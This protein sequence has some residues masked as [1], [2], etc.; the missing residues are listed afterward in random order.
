MSSVPCR[1]AV[2][3][4]DGT[5]EEEGGALAQRFDEF[6]VVAVC[7]GVE[8]FGDGREFGEPAGVRVEEVCEFLIGSGGNGGHEQAVAVKYCGVVACWCGSPAFPIEDAQAW[9]AQVCV[10]EVAVGGRWN[11]RGWAVDWGC[12][13]SGAWPRREILGGV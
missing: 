8:E 4:G 12:P 5:S 13:G 2:D 1:S 3:R 9:A 10:V 6:D 11:S 7:A